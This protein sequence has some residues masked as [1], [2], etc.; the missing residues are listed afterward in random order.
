MRKIR[1][2]M[3]GEER[4]RENVCMGESSGLGSFLIGGCVSQR[5]RERERE[6]RRDK[7][8]WGIVRVSP[9]G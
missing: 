5:G 9:L 4:R 1:G 2:G 7:P 8:Y 3:K 6:N